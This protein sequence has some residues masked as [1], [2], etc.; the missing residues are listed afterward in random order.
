MQK[1]KSVVEE[2]G[3]L[4]EWQIPKIAAKALYASML[5]YELEDDGPSSSRATDTEELRIELT[6][7]DA[8]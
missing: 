2:S 7:D 4:R 6:E 8:I 3:D 1:A 5:E